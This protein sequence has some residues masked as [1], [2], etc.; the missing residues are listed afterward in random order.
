[1]APPSRGGGRGAQPVVALVASSASDAAGLCWSVESS[2]AERAVRSSPW[3]GAPPALR[4]DV[5]WLRCER[6]HP[7]TRARSRAPN[8]L[9]PAAQAATHHARA[10]R[11]RGCAPGSAESHEEAARPALPWGARRAPSRGRRRRVPHGKGQA[12]RRPQPTP[13]ATTTAADWTERCW[14]A[15]NAQCS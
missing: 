1:M 5:V 15:M 12:G 8:L 4:P 9:G 6:S 11:T 7:P 2:A 14:N 13:L 3:T 10:V